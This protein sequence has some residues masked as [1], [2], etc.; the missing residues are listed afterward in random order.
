MYSDAISWVENFALS[1]ETR[2]LEQLHPDA[3]Y[4]NAKLLALS[5]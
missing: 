3:G 5:S 2:D 4:L 1:K